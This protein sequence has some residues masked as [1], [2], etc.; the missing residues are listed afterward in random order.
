MY[1]KEYLAF[2]DLT[3][4]ESKRDF[5][6]DGTPFYKKH[7]IY[8]YKEDFANFKQAIT[9]ATDFIIREKGEDIISDNEGRNKINKEET[10]ENYRDRVWSLMNVK[11]HRLPTQYPK[12][13]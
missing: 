4:T 12:I 5:N 7:K 2:T 8:L 3:I 9:E 1:K 6:E 10:T 13:C 11:L